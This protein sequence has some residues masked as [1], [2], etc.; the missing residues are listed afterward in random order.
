ME[1][2]LDKN[3]RG[4]EGGGWGLK[5]C[6]KPIQACFCTFH[7]SEML[8]N[9]DTRLTLAQHFPN[10]LDQAIHLSWST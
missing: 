9:E 2:I 5:Q 10:L 7:N 4:Q 1:Q 6:G 3:K 8:H